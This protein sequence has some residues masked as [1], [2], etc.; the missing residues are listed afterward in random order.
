MNIKR[1]NSPPIKWYLSNNPVAA[2]TNSIIDENR[3]IIDSFFIPSLLIFI[4]LINAPMPRIRR[5]FAMHEPTIFPSEIPA[6]FSKL[7]PTETASSGVDVPNPIKTAD[8]TNKGIPKYNAVFV[9]PSTSI[10]DPF[11]TK[12]IPMINNGAA[13]ITGS[14]LNV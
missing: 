5:I 10:S 14:I 4:G 7:A 12:I 6:S 13:Y 1:N 11:E 9:V 2:N 3:I 8:I